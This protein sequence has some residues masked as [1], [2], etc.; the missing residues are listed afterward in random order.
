MTAATV[1]SGR[2]TQRG[3][4]RSEWIKFRSLRSSWVSLVATVL[5]VDGIG[6]LFSALHA[7]RMESGAGPKAQFQFDATEVSLRGIYLAQL[8]V[9]V[10]GVLVIT[11]EYGTG[12]IRSSLGAVPRRHPVLIAKALVFA[13]VTFVVSLPT[14]FVG[15][16]LGQ[17]VQSS[18]HA[19]ADLS[20]PGALRAIVGAAV[21]LT[22]IGLLSVGIGFIVRNT[23]GAIA[24]VVGIVLVAPLLTNALPDPYSTDVAKFLPLNIGNRI[25]STTEFDPNLLGPWV[26]IAVLAA[27]AA[28]ALAIGAAVL[29]RRDA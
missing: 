29:A 3:V 16:E 13:L 21:Y 15:F 10:L 4:V 28:I 7:H 6:T 19:Q 25:V 18:T 9:G 12:M 5:I 23:A 11:G 26:G 27:Y 24:T 14:A 22:L 8:A 20:S 2:L 1:M 17:W